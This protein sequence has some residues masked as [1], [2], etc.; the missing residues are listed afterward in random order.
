MFNLRN[1]LKQN[2]YLT[3]A[4]SHSNQITCKR[5][6][7]LVTLGHCSKNKGLKFKIVLGKH[8]SKKTKNKITRK[9]KISKF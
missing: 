6:G 4:E 8:T 3:C 2:D 1:G 7:T 9:I 5:G